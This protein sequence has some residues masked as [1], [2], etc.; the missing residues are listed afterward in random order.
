MLKLAEI[1]VISAL[2][3]CIYCKDLNLD[4][5][6]QYKTAKWIDPPM[7]LK[8]KVYV[9]NFTN[10]DEFLKGAKPKLVETGPYVFTDDWYKE[11]IRWKNGDKSIEYNQLRS[12]KF[13]PSESKGRLRDMVTV[14]NIPMIA[15]LRAMKDGTPLIRRAIGSI[16]DVLNQERFVTLPVRKLLFGYSNPLLKLG[17]DVLPN[18]MKWPHA[19]FGLFVGKNA[20]ADGTLEALTGNGNPNDLGEFTK[21]NG[22]EKLT[23][24]SGDKCNEVKGTDGFIYKPNLSKSENIYL[25]NRDLCRSI[26]L[27]FNKE[28]V[29]ANGIP[30]YRFVPTANVFGTPQEN[31]DNACFCNNPNGQCDVPSGIFNVSSCQFGSP[32]Y[33]SWPHF[34]Q[35]DPK[36]LNT[37]EGLKPVQSKH[38]LTVDV[39][40]KTGNGLGGN[41]RSQVNLQMNKVEGV[42]QAS[43]LRD[44]LI[45]II[46]FSD[47]VES[48]TD[49]EMVQKIKAQL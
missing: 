16:L 7:D 42:K 31:P 28:I 18:E 3:S 25:F 21:F 9:F 22:K 32:I 45:P 14:P 23:W 44:I 34:F 49:P 10:P 1:T 36:L 11:K 43:G 37:V 8:L 5:F 19:T 33:L 12:F 6:D 30:G 35:A 4:D 29:N 40:P 20:T 48:I 24:W 46:W 38:Q 47:D 41:I 17:R 13:V 27:E 15:A 39:Q 2:V 26:P